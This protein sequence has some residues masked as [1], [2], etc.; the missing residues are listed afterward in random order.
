MADENLAAEFESTSSAPALTPDQLDYQ[1]GLFERCYLSSGA[2]AHMLT[3]SGY[4]YCHR[5]PDDMWLGWVECARV[6]YAQT[7]QLRALI[8]QYAQSSAEAARE[9]VRLSEYADNCSI[10]ACE[11]A[12]LQHEAATANALTQIDA[13]LQYVPPKPQG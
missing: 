3:R 5:Q 13:L 6:F 9:S 4:G 10:G 2:L 11:G 12:I 7:E 1:R 8:M